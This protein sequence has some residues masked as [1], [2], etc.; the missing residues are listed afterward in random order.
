MPIKAVRVPEID[1]DAPLIQ[2]H[3]EAL[4]LRPDMISRCMSPDP[5]IDEDLTAILQFFFEGNRCFALLELRGSTASGRFLTAGAVL[6]SRPAHVTRWTLAKLIGTEYSLNADL[7]M[8]LLFGDAD[9][10]ARFRHAVLEDLDIA[11]H[12]GT[13]FQ[14]KAI[15]GWHVIGLRV[16][17]VLEREKTRVP[18]E[19]LIRYENAV[20]VIEDLRAGAR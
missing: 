12:A 5:L 10:L 19:F 2:I 20:A 8:R 14:A 4:E 16:L 11:A 7:A 18:F 1:F 9:A 15:F 17:V 13:D 6:S 3:G